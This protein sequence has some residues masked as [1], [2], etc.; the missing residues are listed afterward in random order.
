MQTRRAS[1]TR[2]H[3][4]SA[5]D[6]FLA[7]T[8][9]RWMEARVW[10][11]ARYVREH[12]KMDR[13]NEC[14]WIE[15]KKQRKFE[16]EIDW[17][18]RTA[19]NNYLFIDW[20]ISCFVFDFVLTCVQGASA[21]HTAVCV[22]APRL[23]AADFIESPFRHARH[24][25]RKRFDFYFLVCYLWQFRFCFTV[26]PVVCALRH[27]RVTANRPLKS[28]Q[29]LWLRNF[30][31]DFRWV[32]AV[33]IKLFFGNNN[34]RAATLKLPQSCEASPCAVHSLA[35]A[36]VHFRQKWC[37]GVR[38]SKTRANIDRNDDCKLIA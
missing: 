26:D 7:L 35:S 22:S 34:Y 9:C 2:A 25:A 37:A 38:D 28:R 6:N 5:I 8:C 19:I 17:Q 1:T 10:A 30:R 24:V 16:A 33:P 21:G 4:R 3:N 12:N 13:Q 36:N 15:V 27:L 23:F 29:N 20:W 18:R 32:F 31:F 11:L 14:L